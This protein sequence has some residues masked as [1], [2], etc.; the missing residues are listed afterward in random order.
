MHLILKVM[1]MEVRTL[2]R[3]GKSSLVVVL[4]KDW[5]KELDL[6]AGDKVV[7]TQEEDG[8]LKILPS[9]IETKKNGR[10]INITINVDNCS[11]PN[12][13]ERILVGNYLVGNDFINIVSTKSILSP[14]YLK[15][16]RKI[17]NKLR[18]VEIVEHTTNKIVLQCVADPIKFTISNILNRML[19]LIISALDYIKRGLRED[20]RDYIKEVF[21]IEEEIDRLY[22]LAI[23]QI[24]TVQKNRALT[25]LVGIESPLHLVGNRTIVKTLEM[26]SDYLEDVAKDTL[27]VLNL[28]SYNEYSEIFDEIVGLIDKLEDVA[29]DVIRSYS[30]LDLKTANDVLNQINGLEKYG[31]E[32][33]EK[34]MS[35]TTNVKIGVLLV[36]IVTRLIDMT[37]SLSIVCEI[38]INRALEFPSD[39]ISCVKIQQID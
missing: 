23:R 34:I 11:E 1:L 38:V 21:Y 7:V 24:L 27:D 31:R 25:K 26:A 18:G 37:R 4:P 14:D 8:T 16:I 9:N 13:I 19:S 12:L 2:L 39:K 17:V 15:T 5:L 10:K 33:I 29:S 22:W 35:S 28:V 32:L 36:R 30:G 20:N 3:L 6:K